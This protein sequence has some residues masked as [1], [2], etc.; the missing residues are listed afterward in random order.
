LRD[1]N[2]RFAKDN[3]FVTGSDWCDTA[4]LG[5]GKNSTACLNSYLL[6]NAKTV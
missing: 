6:E 2:S 4:V 3:H 1:S 5:L